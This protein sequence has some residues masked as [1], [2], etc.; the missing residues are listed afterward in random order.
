VIPFLILLNKRVKERPLIM[1]P[2]CAFIVVGLWLEHLLLVGPA[3]NP[4]L[5]TLPVGPGDL[6]ITVGFLGL[7]AFSVILFLRIFPELVP[8]PAREFHQ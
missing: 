4:G 8:A 6:L 2:L 3:L 5:A 1:I 7:M